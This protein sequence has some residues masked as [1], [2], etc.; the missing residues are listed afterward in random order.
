MCMEIQEKLFSFGDE[1][2]K[3]FHSSLIPTVDNDTIIGVRIPLL[4]QFAKELIRT[5][6]Y[7]EFLC[8]LP[9]KYYDE[10]C[11]H[12]LILG[13]LKDFNMLMFELQRFLPFVDNWATCDI[14]RPKIFS[15]HREELLLYVTEWLNSDREYTV[16][17][18]I[19]V[20]LNLFADKYFDLKYPLYVSQVTYDS[21]YVKMMQA[22]YFATLLAKQWDSVIGYIENKT[23]PEWVHKK[24]VS[25]ALES[26]RLTPEQKDYLKTLK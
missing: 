17:F 14:L 12:A 25:K 2:Y 13:E 26:Y 15:K 21:Y 8:E 16:R 9:H 11:L 20:L 7:G 6:K 19:E 10:N 4:R 22:W 5:E 18:G 24:T 1:K 23:L 3:N